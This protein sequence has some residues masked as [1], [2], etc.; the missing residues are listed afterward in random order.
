VLIVLEGPEAV[1][2]S[3]QL[4]HLTKWLGESHAKLVEV[5]EPGGTTV[6]DHLRKLVLDPAFRPSP[7]TEA[8]LFLASRSELVETVIKRGLEQESVV[9][10]DR[11]FLSTY[12]YQ[13]HGRGLDEEAIRTANRF[14]TDGLVP[15][16]TLL[17]RLPLAES[18]KRL[19]A[20]QRKDRMEEEERDFH[21]RVNA[22]FEMFATPEWQASHPEC[23]K[24]C[25][26][27]ASG[28]EEA[29]FERLKKAVV[30][31]WRGTFS[32]SR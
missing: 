16:V 21:E 24:I 26:I 25:S 3:T 15:D 17:L 31:N 28:T 30:E 19:D 14:A 10:V 32:Y 7:R 2:K 18:R 12:A 29:V 1:G 27:D 5:R 4:R 20:R 13:V 9:V 23:G 22:A 11:F 8:L 6:G